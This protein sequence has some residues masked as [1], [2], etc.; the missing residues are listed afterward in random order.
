MRSFHNIETRKSPFG[1]Y[2]IGYGKSGRVYKIIGESGSWSA[3]MAPNV[4]SNADHKPHGYY[5]VSDLA[6]LSRL[7]DS[8]QA[9]ANATLDSWQIND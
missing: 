4:P 7:L 1:N 5:C 3:V 8:E 9:P 2:R 6:Y